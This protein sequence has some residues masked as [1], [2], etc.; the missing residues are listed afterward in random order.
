MSFYAQYYK[1][2][3][4]VNPSS[5]AQYRGKQSEEESRYNEEI[6][7]KCRENGI[8]IVGL[9]N[10]GDVDSSESLRKHL[11]DNGITVF[12]G[13]EV[14]SAE[15]IHIVCLFPEEK[16]VTQLNRY[17]GALG[18]GMANAGNETSQLTCI[19]IGNNVK[20]FGGFWYAAHATSDN[21]VLK[22][23]KMQNIWKAE[24]LVA[25]Q[26]PDSKDNIDPRYKNIIANTDPEY[27]RERLPAF[28]NACDI[29]KPEDLD[30]ENATTLIKMTSPSFDNFIAAFKDPVSRIKLNSEVEKTYQSSI[31][32][33]S[34]TG[35]YLDGL[36]IEFSDH[37]V[38]IIGG[39]G[40]GKSTIVNLIRYALEKEP[41]DRD[42]RKEF[43]LMIS[44]NLGSNSKVELL[45]TSYA[46][47]GKR[48]RIIRRYNASPVIEDMS[49]N[50]L[51]LRISDLMPTVELYGQNEII[52]A[53]KDHV[54]VYRIVERLFDFNEETKRRI[55][56]AYSQLRANSKLIST[57][58]TDAEVDENEVSDLPA[59]RERFGFFEKAGLKDKLPRLTQLA[60]EEAAF[61]VFERSIP[62]DDIKWPALS[63]DDKSNSSLAPLNRLSED[64]NKRI[65][66][67]KKTYTSTLQ[68][69]LGE[70]N[71]LKGD[72]DT[73]RN[74][75]DQE[76]HDDLKQ[77][78][79]IQDRSSSEIVAEYTTL[80]K[81]IE[82]VT[83][84]QDR[85]GKRDKRLR[86]LIDARG[87][88][89][90]NCRKCWDDYTQDI[91]NQLRTLNR[92]RF[93]DAVRISVQFRQHKNQLL[94]LLKG[95][96][97][98]GD[99]ALAGI[100]YYQNFDVF[101]FADD[102]RSGAVALKDKYHL[103]LAVAEKIVAGLSKEQLLAI[104]EMRLDDVYQI[105]L[106]VNG[107]HKH[108]RTLSKGQQC[109]A[110]L[111][112]LLIESKDPLV[113]DQPEDN[114]DN[115][116]IAESFI[117]AIRE[118]KITRQY[119]FATHNANIPVFGDAELIVAMEE[120]DGKGRIAEGGIG[121]IDAHSVK[122]KVI[123]VLEGGRDA[124]LM[125]EMKYGL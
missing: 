100:E 26:I 12:P 101:S 62:S 24:S 88:L 63:F 121:S 106:L 113:I 10:H 115:A 45:V 109:T 119:I 42:R 86:E 59:L 70:Y 85:I 107:Q 49:G 46:Q 89:I 54:L 111:S 104:E 27:K 110:V 73:Q 2:A 40:T 117:S 97:R 13:F 37:L 58:R 120:V 91:N 83:P 66:E 22:I 77:I 60:S 52:D 102:I 29:C 118:N 44:S 92:K 41:T 8:R 74:M 125:R 105:E 25:V 48:F 55:E 75:Y 116:F 57:L 17:L 72:W 56:E 32:R 7:E 53:V 108:L 78:E 16:T 1:C 4:Q 79:G 112:I 96:E 114:L 84:I 123:S 122:D 14:M 95:I 15:K 124:F 51:K 81:K 3:L 76:I 61:E 94:D 98:I 71:K 21:G 33:M 35:G 5:Y 19:E 39:R 68:W 99:K 90:E 93:K 103:T 38:A 23:G 20:S 64:F 34:V 30:K 65:E 50:V 82:Q 80:I 47:H 18:L 43:D 69:L 9:A 87:T 31:N 6:L 11:V 67:M 28:I 36:E